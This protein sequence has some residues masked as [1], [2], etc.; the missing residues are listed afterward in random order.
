[1]QDN[2]IEIAKLQNEIIKSLGMQSEHVV[3]NFQDKN[4]QIKLQLIT[5][6][7]KHEQSFLLHSNMG[8]DKVDA[9]QK[10]CEYVGNKYKEESSYTLQWALIGNNTLHT[11]YFRA[12]NIYEVLDKFYFGREQNSYTIYSINLNPIS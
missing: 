4:G 12:N 11:S 8:T 9:L 3:F 1:M 10:M 6:N 5:I 2:N 7:P